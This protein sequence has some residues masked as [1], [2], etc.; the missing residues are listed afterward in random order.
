METSNAQPETLFELELWLARVNEAELAMRMLALRLAVP[1]HPVTY[2]RR[3]SA[4][5]VAKLQHVDRRITSSSAHHS[6]SSVPTISQ[7][8]I[9]SASMIRARCVVLV[10]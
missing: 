5:R 3:T 6:P 7:P 8:R 4:T 10:T 9:N 1:L 2:R